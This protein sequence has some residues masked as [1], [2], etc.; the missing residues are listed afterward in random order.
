MIQAR[1]SLAASP[2]ANFFGSF[3]AAIGSNAPFPELGEKALC[4]LCKAKARS[5][6]FIYSGN[7]AFGLPDS[8][9][10]I[11][12]RQLELLLIARWVDWLLL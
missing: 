6:S 3:E 4:S 7:V 10:A 12:E 2:T 8:L 5:C 11:T 9:L 1:L